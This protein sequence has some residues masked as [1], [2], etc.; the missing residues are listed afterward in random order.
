MERTDREELWTK[1]YR[2][3]RGMVRS[4]TKEPE[5][6]NPIHLLAGCHYNT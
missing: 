5:E 6:T 4:L 2:K 1:Y 3:V